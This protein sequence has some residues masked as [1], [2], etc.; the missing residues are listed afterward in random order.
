MEVGEVM[1]GRFLTKL[2]PLMLDMVVV[3]LVTAGPGAM[4]TGPVVV[5]AEAVNEL[6]AVVGML[7]D[8]EVVTGAAPAPTPEAGCWA[9]RMVKA[10]P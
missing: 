5:G 3:G 6:V 10:L 9:S 7:A 4:T 2:L 1:L 8:E